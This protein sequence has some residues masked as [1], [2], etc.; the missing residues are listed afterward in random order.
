M[1]K[2]DFS[3]IYSYSKLS[4]FEK[5]PKQYYFN[6]LDPEIAPIKKQFLKPRDYKTKGQAVHGAI[7]LFYHL[8]EPERTFENLKKCLSRAWFSELDSSQGMP[9]G[10]LG[11]FRDLQHERTSYAQALLMLKKFFDIEEPNPHLFYIPTKQIKDSFYDYEEMIKPLND[12]FSI[13]GKFDRIDKLEDNTLRIIDFKTNK[14]ESN[15]FQLI[16]YKFLAELNFKTLVRI[17]SFYYLNGGEIVDFDV[18]NINQ[19]Q[20]KDQVLKKIDKIQQTK[21]FLP[22]K[23][24]YCYHC[25][26]LEICKTQQKIT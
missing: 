26:F 2:I 13:S 12:N 17:V 3:K 1:K 23:N 4:L 16:F 14:N 8:P 18:S 15:K 21:D 25:D 24:K 9:L 11:G 7:T 22:Q 19:D 20:I 10:K 5:C 6:Y